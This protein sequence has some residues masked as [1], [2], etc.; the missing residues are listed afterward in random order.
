[1]VPP[2]DEEDL[3]NNPRQTKAF[4][5]LEKKLT[6]ELLFLWVLRLLQD[7]PKYAYELRQEFQDRFGFSP[8]TVTNYTVLYLL[9]KEGIVRRAEINTEGERIDRKYYEITELGEKLMREC[10]SFLK[11]TLSLLF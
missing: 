11:D 6:I 9:E 10:K 8:A 4:K 1:M 2:K 7:G 5:R 3:L